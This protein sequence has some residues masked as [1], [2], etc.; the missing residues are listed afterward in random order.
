MIR[1]VSI[2]NHL[3]SFLQEY[4]E[5]KQ[6]SEVLNPELQITSNETEI[7]KDNQFILHT[8]E[9]GIKRFEE[10][11]NITPDNSDTL[12]IRQNRVY[13]KWMDNIPYTYRYLI[14][15]LEAMLGTNGYEILTEFTKYYFKV[16]TKNVLPSQT[17]E[18][19]E[20]VK[21]MI[22]AN[23]VF[24]VKSEQIEN[25]ST[26]IGAFFT[27]NYRKEVMIIE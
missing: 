2:L 11:L 21:E 18:C 22:P 25:V 15:K 4:R 9:T 16:V 19:F 8:N 5:L 3:P 24:E 6:L 12:E 27:S 23:L 17:I 10:M 26:Y 14:T 7:I 20:Y 13:V 1:D